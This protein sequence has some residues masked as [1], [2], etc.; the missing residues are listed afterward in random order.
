MP[1]PVVRWQIVSREADRVAD[2]YAAAFD[3]KVDRSNALGYRQLTSGESSGADGGVW[4]RGEEGH[5]LVQLFIEVDDVA[6]AAARASGLG[7][8]VLVPPSRLPDGDEMALL[9]D[10]TGLSFGLL[11]RR[12]A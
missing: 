8:R 6:A 3:W 2:F 1:N 7:A 11:A 12:P 10:P 4:P 5:D 9:V